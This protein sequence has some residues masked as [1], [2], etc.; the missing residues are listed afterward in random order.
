MTG[1]T[2]ALRA[3]R[4]VADAVLYE[5]YL[6]YPYR[7]SSSKNQ[8]RWQFGVLSPVGAAEAGVG[9]EASLQTD[10]LLDASPATTLDVHLRF[11]HTQWRAVERAAGEGRFR[12][13]E[14]LR[15]GDAEWIAWHEAVECEELFEGLRLD[16][17]A[18]GFRADIRVAGREETEL[19]RDHTGGV[20]GRLVRTRWALT[21]RLAVRAVP[22]AG[23]RPLW[24]LRVSVAN[25]AEWAPAAAAAAREGTTARDLGARRSLIGTH[26]ILCVRDGCFVSTVDPPDWAAEAA[27]GCHQSRCWPVLAGVGDPAGAQTSDVVLATPIILYDHPAVAEESPGALYD[28]TEIDEILTLRIMTMTEEEK[29]AARGTDPRAA[30]II[31]RCDGM[32]PEVFERLHGALR[33]YGLTD[34]VPGAAPG[35]GAP[36]PILLDTDAA[37]FATAG[38]PWWDPAEDASVS[39]GTDAVL[40]GNVRVASGSRVVLR[41]SRRA[42]AQDVFLAGMTATVR[43]VLADVDGGAHVAVTLDDDPASDLHEWYGRYYYFDPDELEALPGGDVREGDLR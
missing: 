33:G 10:C 39:P 3:V 12:P 18:A 2:G 17:L 36:A 4:Q 16:Q 24:A 35:H 22:V 42:D 30:A 14:T 38:A 20:V 27:R 40:V 9:E 1:A 34:P 7:A 15:V 13:V 37:D 31:D 5:G 26:L 6:L 43:A 21:A 11:L 23:P 41:P 28:S 25:T 19:L 32:P 29:L 8:L